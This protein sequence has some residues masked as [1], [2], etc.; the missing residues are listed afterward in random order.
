[1]AEVVINEPLQARRERRD[2]D[3]LRRDVRAVLKVEDDV[4]TTGLSSTD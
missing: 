3:D 2:I 1:M 4:L